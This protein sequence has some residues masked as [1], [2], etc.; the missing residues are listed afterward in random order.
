MRTKNNNKESRK[1]Q[2]NRLVQELEKEKD[3][4]NQLRT[5]IDVMHAGWSL[6]KSKLSEATERLNEKVIKVKEN[7]I[8]EN[9]TS[10]KRRMTTR[11]VSLKKM[12]NGAGT[13][14]NDLSVR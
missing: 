6:D 12:Y 14:T 2:I 5:T 9:K 4:V 11:S 8:E 7:A 13:S 3:N 1:D 10:L